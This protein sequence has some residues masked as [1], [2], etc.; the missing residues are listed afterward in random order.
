MDV[1]PTIFVT[2][3]L[4]ASDSHSAFDLRSV[5]N[6]FTAGH[7]CPLPSLCFTAAGTDTAV[8]HL[9]PPGPGLASRML[10]FIPRHSQALQQSSCAGELPLC[11]AAACTN[12]LSRG[13]QELGRQHPHRNVQSVAPQGVLQIAFGAAW[14]WDRCGEQA[15]HATSF[16]ETSNSIEPEL[17]TCNPLELAA[18]QRGS[19]SG[20]K[21][22]AR[23]KEPIKFKNL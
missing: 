21:K 19:S 12:S 7:V 13:C 4:P 17:F 3:E 2:E 18:A 23:K 5:V 22:Q 8:R 6:S 10:C 9:T 11:R 20:A 1:A 15:S 16:P 14:P